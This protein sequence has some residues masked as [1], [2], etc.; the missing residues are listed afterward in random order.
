MYAF[1]HA[2][3]CDAKTKSNH[4]KPCRCPAVRGKARCRVHGGAKDSGAKLGNTNALRHGESTVEV[5]AFR[6][7]LRQAI[8]YN[9]KLLQE[10][11]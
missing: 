9:K 7:E 8:Q 4:G 3:R 11:G 6:R 10:L 1:D 2:P 5:K